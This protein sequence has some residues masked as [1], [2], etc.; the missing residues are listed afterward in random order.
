MEFE[1]HQKPNDK[2]SL[3][4]GGRT[5]E[6]MVDW[7]RGP[8]QNRRLGLIIDNKRKIALNGPKD[9]VPIDPEDPEISVEIHP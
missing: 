2:V 6:I 4:G 9:T 3:V 5:I 8:K 1:W 7:M